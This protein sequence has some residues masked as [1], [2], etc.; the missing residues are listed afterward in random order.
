MKSS[1]E[2][3]W[4]ND[5]EKQVDHDYKLQSVSNKTTKSELRVP[6]SDVI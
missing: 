2:V 1:D 6:P 3:T 5:M 4:A